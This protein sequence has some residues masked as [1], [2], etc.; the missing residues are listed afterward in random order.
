MSPELECE[1]R[2]EF[3]QYRRGMHKSRFRASKEVCVCS[4]ELT[5]AAAAAQA[6]NPALQEHAL[7]NPVSPDTEI[8]F[9]VPLWSEQEDLVDALDDV[10]VHCM[11]SGLAE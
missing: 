10:D 5:V 11:S 6:S 7:Q 1:R 9:G 2:G 4:V 8:V 3:L